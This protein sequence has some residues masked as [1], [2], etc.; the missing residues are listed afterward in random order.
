MR[1]GARLDQPGRVTAALG[2]HRQAVERRPAVLRGRRLVNLCWR[3]LHCARR[4]RDRG[5]ALSGISRYGDRWREWAARANRRGA[6]APREGR[7]VARDGDCH[8]G[9]RIFGGWLVLRAPASIWRWSAR[10]CHHE[11]VTVTPTTS[12]CWICQGL[13]SSARYQA[14]AF[15]P[16]TISRSYAMEWA[17]LRHSVM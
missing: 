12:A 7:G 16:L 14:P 5:Q 3:R 6:G 13:A 10:R 8:L 2:G 17:S 1:C 15:R 11:P 4:R 9:L